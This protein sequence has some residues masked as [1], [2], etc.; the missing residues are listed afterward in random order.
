MSTAALKGAF[1]LVTITFETLAPIMPTA[2]GDG[3]SYFWKKSL[4][5]VEERVD[6]KNNEY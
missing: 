6:S 3:D 2:D 5:A 1:P 4:V